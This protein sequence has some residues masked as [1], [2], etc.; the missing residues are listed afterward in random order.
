MALSKERYVI[1]AFP[2]HHFE[3]VL[4]SI[5][6]FSFEIQIPRPKNHKNLIRTS[7]I[8]NVNYLNLLK[9]DKFL[10]HRTCTIRHGCRNAWTI[11]FST[12]VDL[13][14]SQFCKW[15]LP[16]KGML[17]MPF[18]D[19]IFNI[20]C[21]ALD[22]SVLK[23]KLLGQTLTNNAIRTKFILNVDYLR[24]VGVFDVWQVLVAP[25]MYNPSRVS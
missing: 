7:F 15:L 25:D 21:E 11:H 2:W 17:Y 22:I 9:I 10:S 23:L 1:H 12:Y 19:P 18:P 4:W 16:R 8:L 14:K 3:Y 5:R 13:V 6:Y 24:W 20:L